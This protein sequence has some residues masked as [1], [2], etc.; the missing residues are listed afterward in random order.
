MVKLSQRA[1]GALVVCIPLGAGCM[2]SGGGGGGFLALRGYPFIVRDMRQKILAVWLLYWLVAVVGE[3]NV[4]GLRSQA[5]GPP[6]DATL[7]HERGGHA[8]KVRV[9]A[10]LVVAAAI[11]KRVFFGGGGCASPRV[12]D[13]ASPLCP[14]PPWPSWGLQA[15]GPHGM[16]YTTQAKRA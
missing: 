5:R 11:P 16:A 1:I 7:G 9:A 14:P 2:V 10:I 15:F 12:S 8:N 3:A 6:K 4:A 13:G